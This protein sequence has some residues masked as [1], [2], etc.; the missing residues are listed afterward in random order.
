MKTYRSFNQ[1]QISLI[2][3]MG[4]LCWGFFI[5]ILKKPHADLQESYDVRIIGKL[6]NTI[7]GHLVILQYIQTCMYP[8]SICKLTKES[9]IFDKVPKFKGHEIHN[10]VMLNDELNRF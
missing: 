10:K 8:N 9:K 4:L 5:G 7:R 2:L 6:T 1:F 3:K